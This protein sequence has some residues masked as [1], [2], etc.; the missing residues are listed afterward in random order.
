MSSMKL[1]LHLWYLPPNEAAIGR[2]FSNAAIDARRARTCWNWDLTV[3]RANA[4][5]A[6]VPQSTTGP[7]IHVSVDPYDSDDLMP[8]LAD[9]SDVNDDFYDYDSDDSSDDN[10]PPLLNYWESD[11]GYGSA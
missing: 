10:M 6:S 3:A 11:S 2:H 8:A 9:H 4:A 1:L 7:G 5:I